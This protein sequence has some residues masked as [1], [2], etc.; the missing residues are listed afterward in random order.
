MKVEPISIKTLGGPRR[1]EVETRS[2]AA[3]LPNSAAG[4]FASFDSI[5]ISNPVAP[6]EQMI[7]SGATLTQNSSDTYVDPNAQP[8]P[9]GDLQAPSLATMLRAIKGYLAEDL[10]KLHEHQD[11][12]VPQPQTQNIKAPAQSDSANAA[13]QA[14]GVKVVDP[15]KKAEPV[16]EGSHP[17]IP[18]PQGGFKPVQTGEAQ[19]A[20]PPPAPSPAPAPA[21]HAPVK[22]EAP[23]QQPHHEHQAA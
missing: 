22:P 15:S 20:P 16:E 19:K 5:E 14:Q 18:M 23:P 1:L 7:G 4:D 13:V 21:Q 9:E 12:P 3:E 17:A 8:S 2:A 10:K 6:P 11:A